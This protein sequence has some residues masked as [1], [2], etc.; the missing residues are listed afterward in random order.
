MEGGSTPVPHNQI[1][2]NP[3]LRVRTL[4]EHP[5]PSHHRN[6]AT[7]NERLLRVMDYV[8]RED[9]MEREVRVFNE[10]DELIERERRLA[11]LSRNNEIK[12]RDELEATQ[13]L[14]LTIEELSYYK[15][16]PKCPCPAKHREHPW[17]RRGNYLNVKIPC[18]IGHMFREH[19]YIDFKAPVNIMS[20]LYYNWIMSDKMEPRK[21]PYNPNRLCNFVGRAKGLHVFVGNFTYLCDFMIL[22]DV[23]GI[24]DPHLG[25]IVLG[26]PFIEASNMTYNLEEGI[27]TFSHEDEYVRYMMPHKFEKFRDIED[28][29]VDNIPTFEEV[30]QNNDRIKYS[31]C[32]ALGSEYKWNNVVVRSFMTAFKM[33]YA[34]TC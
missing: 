21:N 30:N 3:A 12:C 29:D 18:M 7:R 13:N 6:I 22:E 23:R 5:K 26:K 20:R 1:Q 19:T 8:S 31:G 4:R 14:S 11:Q 33:R 16:L 27:A 32:M 28:L 15:F 17:I 10:P 25:E 24:I 9:R 34:R 2:P